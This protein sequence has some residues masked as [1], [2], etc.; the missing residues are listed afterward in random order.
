MLSGLIAG[1]P[2]IVDFVLF[3]YISHV[4]LA[5]LAMGLVLVAIILFI[6]GLILDTIVK[7]QRVNYE[8][9]LNFYERINK[10]GEGVMRTYKLSCRINIIIVIV[11]NYP[12]LFMLI[13]SCGIP[14]SK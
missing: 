9:I 4:P 1:I 7:Y 2:V 3:R 13:Y 10:N 12:N 5:I 11:L 8:F 14:Y 6:N